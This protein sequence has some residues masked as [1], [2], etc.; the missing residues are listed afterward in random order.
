M[1]WR[2]EEHEHMKGEQ[3]VIGEKELLQQ[4]Y[5]KSNKDIALTNLYCNRYVQV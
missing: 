3:I 5:G 2:R 1:D 4:A